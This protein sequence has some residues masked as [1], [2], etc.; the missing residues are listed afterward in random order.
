VDEVELCLHLSQGN[1]R[2]HWL[3]VLVRAES[4]VGPKLLGR[5]KQAARKVLK[6]YLHNFPL[7]GRDALTP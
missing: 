1:E 2:Q 5:L 3:G 7:G 4:R 6:V